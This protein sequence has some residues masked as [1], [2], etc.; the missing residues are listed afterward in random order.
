MPLIPEEVI[1]EI[2]ARANL[3]EI[4]LGYVPGL[5]QAGS[6]W[7]GCCPFHQEKTPS[8]IVNPDSNTYHCFGCGAGGNVFK[9]VPSPRLNSP[10][11]R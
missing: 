6:R 5:K 10:S 7:K 1:D 4:V 2:A 8:F 11:R 9:F 3:A